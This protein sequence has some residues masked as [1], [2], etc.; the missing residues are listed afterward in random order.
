MTL[1]LSILWVFGDFQ[2]ESEP[3]KYGDYFAVADKVICSS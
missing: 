1:S 2:K 3:K